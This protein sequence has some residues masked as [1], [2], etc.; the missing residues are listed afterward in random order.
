MGE[1]SGTVVVALSG[2][3][4]SS[5]A[6]ALLKR[7]GHEVIG[8]HLVLPRYDAETASEGHCRA[9]QGVDNAQEVAAALGIPF[10]V[11]DV[12]GE[13]VDTV[14]KNFCDE[15]AL[16]RTPNP[17]V[18]CNKWLKFGTLRAEGGKLGADL[19]ATGHYVRKDYDESTG[20]WVLRRGA[21]GDDQSYF[22]CALSQ[23]QLEGA[24]FPLRGL[25]KKQVRQM[26]VEFGLPV[27]DKPASQD[28]C[29]LA[30]RQYRDFLR[31]LRPE[32][33]QPGPVLHVASRDKLGEHTGI[34]CYTIGQRRGLGIAW[35]EPLFVVALEPESNAV[36]VGEREHLLRKELVAADMNWTSIPAPEGE[37][38]AEVA[39]RYNHP[40]CPC[41]VTPLGGG[42]AR[43]AFD[44][45]QEAPTPGQAAVL[46]QAEVMLGGGVIEAAS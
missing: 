25:A 18:R 14:V 32:L 29:F 13:F 28:L 17:C 42:R 35:D 37:I 39:I 9:G 6:A 15:Y 12:C 4:D 43:V 3:V 30:G 11:L 34:G 7:Q 36:L 27:H 31:R 24:L 5:V 41:L 22:L 26:A 21:A 16:G 20:R 44:R 33:F 10:H 19:V 40:A 8:M 2:G 46:Y 23:E 1:Q 45:L 38:R